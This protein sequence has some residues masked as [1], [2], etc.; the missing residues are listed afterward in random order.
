MDHSPQQ[1]PHDEEQDVSME[2]LLR[3][4][5]GRA[6]SASNVVVDIQE[7]NTMFSEVLEDSSILV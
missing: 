2:E 4:L 1:L 5:P 3:G 6:Q 7:P